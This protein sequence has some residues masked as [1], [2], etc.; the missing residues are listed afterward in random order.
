MSMPA[1]VLELV[2]TPQSEWLLAT[3]GGVAGGFA[4]NLDRW[5]RIAR[6]MQDS[7]VLRLLMLDDSL[8][9]PMSRQEIAR[10]VGE[11]SPLLPAGVQIAY[12]LRDIRHIEN[13]ELA[14]LQA[15]QL[16]HDIMV[17]GDRQAAERWLRYG[18]HA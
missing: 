14:A 13:T 8:G 18:E 16:G 12:V 17:F 10:L 9:E 6:E 4:E 15:R 3:L 2:M 11:I 7:G 5:Q 1:P